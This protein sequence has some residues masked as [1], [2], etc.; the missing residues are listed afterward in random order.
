MKHTTSQTHILVC[1]TC[2]PEGFTGDDTERPGNL[3]ARAISDA[4]QRSDSV[5]GDGSVAVKW[6][7]CLSVCK[8]PCTAAISAPGKFTY[9]I[10]DL[11]PETDVT[12]LL[13][14]A[15]LYGESGD[16]VTPWRARPECVRKHTIA[17]VPAPE[18]MT[19]LMRNVGEGDAATGGM[20]AD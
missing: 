19:D 4:M 15:R 10:G 17:R 1:G 12:D 18:M 16:G 8:R 13:D 9:V 11:D 3:L 7:K 20:D 14:F 6:V 5:A 2:K